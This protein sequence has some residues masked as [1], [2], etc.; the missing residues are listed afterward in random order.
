MITECRPRFPQ[1]H[2]L[3][4]SGRVGVFDI[5]I[6]SASNDP[7]LMHDYRPYWNFTRFECPLRQAQGFLHPELIGI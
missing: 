1:R 7:T 3:S 2:D 4:V 6:K 5:P